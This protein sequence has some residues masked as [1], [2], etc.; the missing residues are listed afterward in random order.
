MLHKPIKF[1]A[2]RDELKNEKYEYSTEVI[3]D[4]GLEL[5]TDDVMLSILKELLLVADKEMKINVNDTG[6]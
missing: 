4:N 5:P 2:R 6:E 3:Y 1:T